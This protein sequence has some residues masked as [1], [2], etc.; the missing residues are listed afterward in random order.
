M[1]IKINI[2]GVRAAAGGELEAFSRA[3]VRAARRAIN[4]SLRWV[5]NGM[6]T[7]MRKQVKGAKFTRR[8]ATGGTNIANTWRATA[9]L[10][11]DPNSS[12][13]ATYTN[14]P[15]MLA[16]EKGATITGRGGKKWLA[17]P[18]NVGYIGNRRVKTKDIQHLASKLKFVPTSDPDV[19]L[20]VYRRPG[21]KDEPMFWLYRRVRI[22]KRLDFAGASERRGDQFPA[23]VVEQWEKFAHKAGVE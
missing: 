21:Q 11:S 8:A 2:K 14:W 10:K 12:S 6:K 16:F 7:D 3:Q 23:R 17:V 4:S 9:R 15:A 18:F 19:A 1:T 22:N 20:L 5:S 13:A